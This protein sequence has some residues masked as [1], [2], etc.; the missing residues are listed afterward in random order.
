MWALVADEQGQVSGEAIMA[1]Y[2]G[3]LFK[4]I[5]KQRAEQK[6]NPEM[7]SFSKAVASQQ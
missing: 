7:L 2:D 4:V 3:T 1:Q 6:Q 5:A